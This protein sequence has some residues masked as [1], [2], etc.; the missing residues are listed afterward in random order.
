MQR[1]SN[2][3]FWQGLAFDAW[4]ERKVDPVTFSLFPL[5]SPTRVR[6]YRVAMPRSSLPVWQVD[7]MHVGKVLDTTWDLLS[8]CSSNWRYLANFSMHVSLFSQTEHWCLC[9]VHSTG[10]LVAGLFAVEMSYLDS[11]CFFLGCR[12]P[13]AKKKL[14]G[15]NS[16]RLLE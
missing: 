1:S 7:E 11:V 6:A 16:I 14:W 13:R 5:L 8:C 3:N 4:L 15:E 2:S 10:F 12:R 9:W